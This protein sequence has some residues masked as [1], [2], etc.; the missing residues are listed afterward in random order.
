MILIYHLSQFLCSKRFSS[1]QNYIFLFFTSNLTKNKFPKQMKSWT[2]LNRQNFFF[3]IIHTEKT[4]NCKSCKL[5]VFSEDFVNVDL[6][7]LYCQ[8]KKRERKKKNWFKVYSGPVWQKMFHSLF[9]LFPTVRIFRE[10][11]CQL[12]KSN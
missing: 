6:K 11:L 10:Q 9:C 3:G 2:D 8:R 5:I 7:M 1:S 12:C 4:M